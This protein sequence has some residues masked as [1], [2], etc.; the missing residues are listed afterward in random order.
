MTGYRL[1]HAARADIVSILAWS[2]EQ[3]GDEAPRRY[4]SSIAAAMRDAASQGDDLGQAA[5]PE[6][7]DGVFS[8]HLSRTRTSSH[9]GKVGRPRRFLIRRRDGDT[10]VIGRALHEAMDLRRNLDPSRGWD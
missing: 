8:W 9:G 1:S 6:L 5:R 7:G 10:L 2:Q 4:Q 3:F